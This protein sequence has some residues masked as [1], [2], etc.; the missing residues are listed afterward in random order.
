MAAKIKGIPGAEKLVLHRNTKKGD[1][2]KITVNEAG[3]VYTI[4]KLDGDKATKLGKGSNPLEL[5]DKYIK[6]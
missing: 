1:I 4:Y 3:N 2:Y 6:D 5:E